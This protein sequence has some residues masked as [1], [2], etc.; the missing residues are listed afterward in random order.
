MKSP[1]IAQNVEMWD[2]LKQQIMAALQEV[3]EASQIVNQR[4][5]IDT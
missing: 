5:D 1:R 3:E 4:L 2:S